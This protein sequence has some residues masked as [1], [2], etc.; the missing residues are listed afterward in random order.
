MRR[1]EISDFQFNTWRQVMKEAIGKWQLNEYNHDYCTAELEYGS[2]FIQIIHN[3]IDEVYNLWC[4]N[5]VTDDYGTYGNRVRKQYV[6]EVSFR[7]LDN[8]MME[9]LPKIECEVLERHYLKYLNLQKVKI[10][11]KKSSNYFDYDYGDGPDA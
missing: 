2:V 1:K 3:N 6:W 5:L 10:G 8:L 11:S 7:K 9:L 4:G